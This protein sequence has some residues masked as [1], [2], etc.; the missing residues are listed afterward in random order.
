MALQNERIGEKIE[1]PI[2]G[3][4]SGFS[5]TFVLKPDWRLKTVE[6]EYLAKV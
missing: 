1:E 5:V 2:P 4:H 6:K 3:S